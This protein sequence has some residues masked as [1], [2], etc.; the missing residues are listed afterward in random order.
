MPDYR[1]TIKLRMGETNSGVRYYSR[2]DLEDVRKHF[3]KKVYEEYSKYLVE[4][5][6]IERIDEKSDGRP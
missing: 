4:K 2:H 5:I 1:I 6:T 3:E